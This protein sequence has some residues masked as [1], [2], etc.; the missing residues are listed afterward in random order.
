MPSVRQLEP[1]DQRIARPDSK[2]GPV[3]VTRSGNRLHRGVPAK[4]GDG[5]STNGC[6]A[7]GVATVPFER[8]GP[9]YCARVQLSLTTRPRMAI[10]VSISIMRELS[11]CRNHQNAPLSPSLRLSRR[12]S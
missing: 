12:G 9:C 4:Y 6:D 7:L 2:L 8:V 1:N 3:T 11:N 10:S 5:Q